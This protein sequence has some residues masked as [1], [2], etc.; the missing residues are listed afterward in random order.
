MKILSI[1]LLSL[2]ALSL[3][4][5]TLDELN[6]SW[7]SAYDAKNWNE[8]ERLGL[9]IVKAASDN[10]GYMFNLICVQSLGGKIDAAL[11]NV[12]KMID[13]GTVDFGQFEKDSDLENMR[14]TE[15]YKKIIAALKER[16]NKYKLTSGGQELNI[17]VPR[18]MEC[19]AVMLYL[20]NPDHPVLTKQ[21]EHSYLKKID[22]YF[23]LYKEHRLVKQIAEMYPGKPWQSN[24]RA[25]HN[26]RTLY[27]YDKYDTSQIVKYPIEIKNELAGIV[28]EFAMDTDFETFYTQNKSFYNAMKKIV[29]SNYSFGSNVIEFF[30][31]NFKERF[32]R[33]NFYFTPL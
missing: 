17:E 33:F 31:E 10:S 16:L 24:L 25:H 21:K 23:V 22:A 20:G 18:L 1:I 2:C 29:S 19:Y 4:A 3:S 26:L 5:Q 8:A 28:R 7:S 27:H 12:Q 13:N 6:S 32:S 11:D 14:D 15:R 9:E 30:N